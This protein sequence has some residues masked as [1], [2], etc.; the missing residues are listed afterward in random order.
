MTINLGGNKLK[1]LPFCLAFLTRLENLHLFKN[2]I[3]NIPDETL[4]LRL[5]SRVFVSCDFCQ[6]VLDIWMYLT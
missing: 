6:V 4:G 3:A 5:G 2:E 1:S